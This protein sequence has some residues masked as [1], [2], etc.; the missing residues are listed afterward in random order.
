MILKDKALLYNILG[1]QNIESSISVLD[2]VRKVGKWPK[3]KLMYKNQIA[4]ILLNIGE[5][6]IKWKTQSVQW[7]LK[8]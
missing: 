6:S 3:T 4:S 1:Y 2:K 5:A 8:S 7:L